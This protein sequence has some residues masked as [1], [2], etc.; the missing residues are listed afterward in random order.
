M[1]LYGV[2]KVCHL[3][4]VDRSFRQQMRDDP[5]QAL[6][7]LPLTEEE[8]AAFLAGDVAYLCKQ[9]AH[10]FLMSRL[11]RFGSVGLTRDEYIERMRT[12]LTAAERQQL[13]GR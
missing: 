6:E 3:T 5:A 8:R 12:L 1:S 11:P 10:T 7:G 4:Q 9:G 2:N 13:A